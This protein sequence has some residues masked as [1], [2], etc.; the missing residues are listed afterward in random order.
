MISVSAPNKLS[1]NAE[2][3]LKKRYL[4]RDENDNIVETID[5]F[6][7]RVSM[8]RSDYREMLSS[9]KFLPNSPTLFNLGTGR[10]TL[11]ACFKFDVPDSMD[12]I[13]SVAHK[14]GLVQKFGG[15]VGYALSNLRHAGA[16]INSTHGKACGPI[17]V[18]KHYQS[19]AEMITQGGKRDGAQMAI[20]SVDHPDI[21]EF[22]HMKDKDP[23]RFNTFNISVAVT[24]KFMHSIIGD[25][26]YIDSKNEITF[27][28]IVDSAW[29]TGDPG[30]YFID[31]AEESNPTPWL[32][33][34]TG[35]NP[36]AEVPLLDNE[37]CLLG[38]VNLSKFVTPNGWLMD[39][40]KDTV[41]LAVEYLDDVLDRNTFPDENITKAVFLTRKLG[42][43]VMGWADALAIQGVAYDSEQAIQLAEQIMRF[44]DNVA[45]GKS[46]Q[47]GTTKGAAPC[48]VGGPDEVIVRNTTLT[49]IAP[50]GSISLIA[51][52]SSGIE[53]HYS[54]E[55][56]RTMGDG[57]ILNESLPKF[58]IVPKTAMEIGWQWHVKH[59]AAFQKY[60]DLAV[61]KTINMPND[62][63][64]E[65]I[66]DAYIMMW[67]GDV[68]GYDI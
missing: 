9:L 62:A 27:D 46:F 51:G 53:P 42:L 61:S 16:H 38:S 20:L 67:R 17:R 52:C 58:S 43:G 6:W 44:I 29:R 21:R 45:S 26:E 68:R 14:A 66:R 3:I 36:C 48:L 32:G 15:G 37:A 65:D 56:T 12:G 57:T 7:D 60:T 5:Q 10:G 18:I 59:Q 11:S 19:L 33:K 8:G 13:L 63:T 49:C 50:T 35:T 25:G 24:D 4:Q 34:L 1:E 30:L 23:Q 41:E 54:H 55:W 39:E 40:L 47:L 64:R 22:I 28:E 31:K 2:I